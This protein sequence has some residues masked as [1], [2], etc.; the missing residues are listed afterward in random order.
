MAGVMSRA[1][2][3]VTK[4]AEANNPFYAGTNADLLALIPFI[5]LSALLYW[6][7]R[8]SEVDNAD[9]T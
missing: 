3:A 2:S 7:G 5:L 4:W 9:A 1:D 6:V 8:R